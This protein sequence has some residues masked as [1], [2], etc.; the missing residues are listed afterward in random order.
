MGDVDDLLGLFGQAEEEVVIL[1]AVVFHPL[2]AAAAL[3]QGAAED[4]Q[5][6]DIVVG[7]EVVQHEVRLEVVEHHVLHLA[8]KGGLVGIDEVRLLLGDGFGRIPQRT[9]V[10]DVIMVQQGDVRAG[11]HRKAVVGVAGDQLVLFQL[12]VADAR[13]GR[14]AGLNLLAHGGVLPGVHAAQLPVAVGLVHDG[15]QQLLQKV[16]RGVV[17]RHHDADLRPGGLVVC[18]PD[19]QLHRGEA[20][21]PHRHAGEERRI[22]TA[23]TGLFQHTGNALGTQLVQEDKE[24]EGV[25]ELAALADRIAGGPGH[26][27]EGGA[28]DLVQSLLQ[29]LFVAAAQGEVAAQPLDE[30]C[31]LAAGTLRTDHPVPQ[32]VEFFLV[33]ADHPHGAGLDSAEQR[34]LL[35]TAPAAP[36]QI[37]VVAALGQLFRPCGQGG[38]IGAH[39]QDL[40]GQLGGQFDPDRVFHHQQLRLGRGGRR[41][42]VDPDARTAQRF[43]QQRTGLLIGCKHRSRLRCQ[44][45]R[46]ALC[47]QAAALCSLSRFL[48]FLQLHF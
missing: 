20:V 29:L 6:T 32:D 26:L 43:F 1:T 14:S 34:R 37:T 48:F 42:G 5:M 23:G 30:G 9:G 41:P 40:F 25:P 47:Q 39:Q 3:H 15:I 36:L 11:G 4:G 2:T 27:P 28:C 21:G 18:L 19:Q 17:Q 13:V 22:H 33:A 35:G 12:L 38:G 45:L 10:Q 7:T 16:Q 31:F 46:D 24:R 8:L 44:L